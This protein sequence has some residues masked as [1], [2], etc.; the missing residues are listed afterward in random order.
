MHACMYALVRACVH[1]HARACMCVCIAL[2][3]DEMGICL[4]E[5]QTL[6]GRMTAGAPQCGADD[7]APYSGQCAR[8]AR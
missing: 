5:L 3:A 2:S 7:A 4:L 6:L 8:G 1:V